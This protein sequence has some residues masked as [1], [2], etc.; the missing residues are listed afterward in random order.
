M[1]LDRIRDLAAIGVLVIGGAFAA[2][3]VVII[4]TTIRMA[5]LQRGR[6]IAIMRLV[7]ATDGFIRRPF[8][9]QG[10]IKGMLGGCVA[11]GLSYGAYVLINRWLIQAAFFTREQAGAVV[12]FGMLIG[13]VGSATSVG[14]HLRRV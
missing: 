10:A 14:R 4:G 2:A 9:L 5:V 7:G 1:K 6:E 8:L 11:I 13:L 3:S 12:V